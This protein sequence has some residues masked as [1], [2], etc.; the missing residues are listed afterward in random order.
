MCVCW[1]FL[2]PS[3]VLRT[4]GIPESI[5]VETITPKYQL[6][7][8]QEH[9]ERIV[10][11]LPITQLHLAMATRYLYPSSASKGDTIVPRSHQYRRRRRQRR[12]QLN[13][14]PKKKREPRSQPSRHGHEARHSLVYSTST[15]LT[16]PPDE[17]ETAPHLPHQA[18]IN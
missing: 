10:A 7:S 4:P 17:E 15:A 16:K 1:F 13:S 11:G 6:A 3:H 2:L 12:T 9:H 8:S 5:F 18:G 14:G